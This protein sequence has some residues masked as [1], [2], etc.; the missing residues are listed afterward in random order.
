L[1]TNSSTLRPYLAWPVFL[2]VALASS[3]AVAQPKFDPK[4]LPLLP[5]Y[6][7]YTQ[8]YRQNVPGGADPAQIEHWASVLGA[9]NFHHLHHYCYGLVNTNRALY[10]SSNKQERNYELSQS[11]REFDYVLERVTP[12][13]VLLPEILTKRGENLLRLGNAPQAVVDLNRAIELKPDHWPPYAALSDYFKG[14]GDIAS[15]RE[16]AEKGLAAAPGTKAL[17]R[18]LTDLGKTKASRSAD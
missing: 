8:D 10:F 17:E 7:K 13:L 5:P 15:A 11:V 3:S 18:R 2:L 9:E 1:P 6:C 4:L 14:L 12:D 16:W